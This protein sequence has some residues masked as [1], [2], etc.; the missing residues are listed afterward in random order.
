MSATSHSS[1]CYAGV[2]KRG[3]YV[4]NSIKGAQERVGRIV[5]MHANDREEVDEIYSGEIAAIVGLKR[6]RRGIRFAIPTIR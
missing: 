4:Y 3:S 1:A 5:R 6:R 2:L